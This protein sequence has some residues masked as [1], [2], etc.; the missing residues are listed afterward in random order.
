MPFY[1]FLSI[2]LF[3]GPEIKPRV[4]VGA[5]DWVGAEIWV[6]IGVKVQKIASID[7]KMPL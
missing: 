5:G 6:I 1:K 2:Y 7:L 4:G 3:D